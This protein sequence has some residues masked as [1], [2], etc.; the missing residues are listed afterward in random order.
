MIQLLSAAN[1]VNC[2]MTLYLLKVHL[3]TFLAISITQ[4]LQI[5]SCDTLVAYERGVSVPTNHENLKCHA[6]NLPVCLHL[7]CP[8]VLHTAVSVCYQK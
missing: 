8:L 2:V 5:L 3:Q 4:K 7:E 1:F 6:Y